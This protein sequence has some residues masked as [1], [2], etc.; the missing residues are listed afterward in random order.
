VDRTGRLVSK[1]RGVFSIN[2]PYLLA[3]PGLGIV[4]DVVASPGPLALIRVDP[5]ARIARRVDG[6]FADGWSGPRAGLTQFA[7]LPG[8][9]RRV[10][11]RV[12]RQG[13]G[14]ADVPG[15]V[16]ITA[17]PLR[18]TEAGPTVGKATARRAWTVHSGQ[19]RTFDIPVPPAPFRIEVV[20]P[21]FSPAQFGQPD[22]RQLGAQLSFA[23]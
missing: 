3:E 23:P 15:R 13:W 20:T 9:A 16:T 12:S 6:L 19:A 2:E 7:P 14:G 8:G 1:A 18:M 21:T 11:V 22:T 4:G 5:P 17:G 10:R